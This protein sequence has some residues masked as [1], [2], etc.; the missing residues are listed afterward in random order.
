MNYG[1]AK[2]S[3]KPAAE[4]RSSR[5]KKKKDKSKSK[6]ESMRKRKIVEKGR[7]LYASIRAFL[8]YC[9]C[10]MILTLRY[11]GRVCEAKL[12]KVAIL[13]LHNR[14]FRCPSSL[15]VFDEQRLFDRTAVDSC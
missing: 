12:W 4:E 8:S 7:Y 2:N 9:T 5:K 15:D 3:E 10:W 14:S 1:A 11:M 6:K 13:G